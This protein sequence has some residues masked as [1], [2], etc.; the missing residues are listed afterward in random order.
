MEWSCPSLGT[1]K[2]NFDAA[3]GKDYSV[4]AAVARDWRG[5]LV[6]ALSKKANVTVLLEVNLHVRLY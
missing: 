3:I 6:F 5:A 2:I 4:I 1:M